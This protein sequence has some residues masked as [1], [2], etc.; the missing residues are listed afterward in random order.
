MS[1]PS[2]TRT[3]RRPRVAAALC[4]LATAA[5]LI[6]A[7]VLF[8]AVRSDRAGGPR[9]DPLAPGLAALSDHELADLLPKPRDFPGSWT[10]DQVTEL[11]DTFGY[12]RYHVYDEGLGFRPAECFGVVGVASTGALGAVRVF[13]HDPA[14]PPEVAHRKDIRLMVAREF[15]SSGFDAL[16]DLVSRC[17]GFSNAAAASYTVRILEDSRPDAGAQRFRYALTTTVGGEPTE[18]TRT[19]YYAY[20]RQSGLI[21]SGS[22]SAGHQDA[23]NDLFEATLRRIAGT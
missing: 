10:V 3:S 4:V 13:G 1:T 5:V 6:T 16:V 22:A 19:D 17:L 7:P 2:P 14:D 11:S 23:F 20:A 8:A 18:A 21:L 9:P 12:F 15:D